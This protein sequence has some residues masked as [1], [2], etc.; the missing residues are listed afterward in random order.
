MAAPL[1]THWPLTGIMVHILYT[2]IGVMLRD[3]IK[4]GNYGPYNWP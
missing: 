4:G 1:R 2:S 3:D